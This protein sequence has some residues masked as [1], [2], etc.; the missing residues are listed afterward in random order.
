MDMATQLETENG[1]VRVPT[2][3]WPLLVAVRAS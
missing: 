2:D 1:N 3:T